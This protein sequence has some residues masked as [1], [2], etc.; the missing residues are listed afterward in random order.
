MS[1]IIQALLP[2]MLL[3]ALGFVLRKSGAIPAEHWRGIESLLFWLLFPALLIVTLARSDVSFAALSNF[4]LALFAMVFL[5]TLIAYAL[6]QPLRRMLGMSDATFTSFFQTSTR[7]HGFIAFAIVERL[8]GAHGVAVLAI[9]FAMMVPWLNIANITVL[10]VH[11]GNTRPTPRMVLMQLLRN[12]ILWGIFLGIGWKLAALPATGIVFTTL[13]L[14]GRGALGISLLALGAGLS[15]QALKN[16]QRE[17]ILTIAIKLILAPLLA[18]ALAWLFDVRGEALVIM[19][20]A[21]AVPTAVNGY[22]LARK[23]GGDAEF[24]AAAATAQ[25][26]VSFLTMPLFIWLVLNLS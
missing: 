16:A 13:E 18:F 15:W 8:H 9:A 5:L 22:V 2:V 11:A 25:V 3:I 6:R 20:V 12:P 4:A 23:M 14:L 1:L 17:V 7:W 24:Y 19:I 10:A 26:A 21:A